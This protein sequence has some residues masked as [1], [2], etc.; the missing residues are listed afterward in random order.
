M[1]IYIKQDAVKFRQLQGN[2]YT[3]NYYGIDTI[4]DTTTEE[5]VAEINS[6]AS[7]AINNINNTVTTA[8][9][10][11]TSTANSAISNINTAANNANTKATQLNNSVQTITNAIEHAEGNG[12]DPTLTLANVAAD[13]K[14]T[15]DAIGDLKSAVKNNN[16]VLYNANVNATGEI[17]FASQYD[18]YVFQTPENGFIESLKTPDGT[19]V[20]AYFTTE[21]SVGSTSYNSSRTVARGAEINNLFVPTGCDYIAIRQDHSH[22]ASIYP[23]NAIDVAQF[24][25]NQ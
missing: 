23:Q 18:L 24:I 25:A 13:A 6:A 15:G 3:G 5:K 9:S 21:P 8:N 4:S 12:V 20:Y 22:A 19:A 17:I 10:T 7:S 11:I 16:K 1:P 14:A 2:E